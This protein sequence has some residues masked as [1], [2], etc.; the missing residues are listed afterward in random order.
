MVV[1]GEGG[2]GVTLYNSIMANLIGWTTTNNIA[3]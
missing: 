3:S 2:E 1:K